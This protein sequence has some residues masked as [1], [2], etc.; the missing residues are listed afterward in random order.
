MVAVSAC[1]VDA[2][3][4]HIGSLG[5]RISVHVDHPLRQQALNQQAPVVLFE[6][7]DG[8]AA[9]KSEYTLIACVCVHMCHVLCH[10]MSCVSVVSWCCVLCVTCVV[11]MCCHVLLLCQLMLSCVVVMSA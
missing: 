6:T 11:V 4:W 7:G 2:L 10:V 9:H 1:L 3:A 5:A 8:I